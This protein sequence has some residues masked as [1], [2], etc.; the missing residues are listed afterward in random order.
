MDTGTGAPRAAT[1]D[2]IEDDAAARRADALAGRVAVTA[3][4]GADTDEPDAE[5]LT[6]ESAE[7]PGLRRR[8]RP[9]PRRRRE[10]RLGGTSV[11]HWNWVLV[12]WAVV[13]LGAGV[14]VAT[15][16][17][18]FIGGVAGGWIGTVALWL[19]M[20]LPVVFAYRMSTPRGLLRFR[21][22][23]L[24][25]GLVLGVALRFVQGALEAAATGA[26]TWPSYGTV[27][28]ALPG[29]WWLQELLIPVVVG[30]VLEE[31]FFHGFLLVA[32]YTV[33]RR[34]TEVRIVA[35]LGAL[36]VSTGLF[37]LL[38]QLTGSLVPTWDGAVS[39]ALVGATGGLLVLL[40]GRI[41]SAVLLHIAF[42]GGYV[43][44]ALAGTMLGVG[45]A[46]GPVL[47]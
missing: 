26:A 12:G 9:R 24:L 19:A 23:D 46:S 1:P 21:P 43:L 44:L 33:F 25:F 15:A 20:L 17:T 4:A 40:T 2:S 36:L 13:A 10:W 34:L 47:S 38:H 3:P 41:W 42:N 31:F 29:D 11:Q 14:L 28:G 27:D 8:S 37:V 45:A 16:A 39:I 35:G 6:D 7:E 32:L 22:A 5:A 18:E 30:P